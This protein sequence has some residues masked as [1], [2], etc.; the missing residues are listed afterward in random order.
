VSCAMDGAAEQGARRRHSSD[1]GDDEQR[2]T[3]H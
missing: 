1:Y 2:S 3:G